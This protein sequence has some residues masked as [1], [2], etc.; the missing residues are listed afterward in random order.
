MLSFGPTP[1]IDLAAWR[2]R[3]FGLVEQEVELDWQ[4]LMAL[5]KVTVD[6]EFHCVTQW[7][8]L[9]NHLGGRPVLRGAEAGAAEA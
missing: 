6:A 1:K 9:D 3:V 7:S 5:P 2:F 8:R 4:Q